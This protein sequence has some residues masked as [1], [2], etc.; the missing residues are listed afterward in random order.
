MD[1]SLRFDA[2]TKFL[3]FGQRGGFG[4]LIFRAAFLNTY[5]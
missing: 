5:L 2:T 1:L 3:I 4:H